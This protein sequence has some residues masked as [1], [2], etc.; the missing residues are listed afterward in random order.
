MQ[1]LEQIL[2][3]SSEGEL[4]K[5]STEDWQNRITKLFC[6]GLATVWLFQNAM[7]LCDQGLSVNMKWCFD[8]ECRTHVKKG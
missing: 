3:G 4:Y 8:M 5:L 1:N 6:G 2:G 7:I